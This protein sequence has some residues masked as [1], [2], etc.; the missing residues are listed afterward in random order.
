MI[1]FIHFIDMQIVWQL[2]P[3]NYL[4]FKNRFGANL[5]NTFLLIRF[6][7]SQKTIRFQHESQPIN[8]DLVPNQYY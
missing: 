4:A 5:L 7:A 1:I 3:L 6:F 2:L 8:A